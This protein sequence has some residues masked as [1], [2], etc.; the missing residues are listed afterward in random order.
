MQLQPFNL[1]IATTLLSIVEMPIVQEPS[2]HLVMHFL[3]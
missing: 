2:R 3:I 1:A